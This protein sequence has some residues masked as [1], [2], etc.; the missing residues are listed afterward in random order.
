MIV[1]CQLKS[2]NYIA[3]EK[4]L[5][6]TII[7]IKIPDIKNNMEIFNEVFNEFARIEKKFSKNSEASIIWKINN[8]A[9][10][11]TEFILDSEEKN[12]FEKSKYYHEL[13]EGYFDITMFTLGQFWNF[14]KSEDTNV[15]N[16]LKKMEELKQYIG[17][18]NIILSDTMV[19]LKNQKLKID[20]GGIAKGYAIDRAV[21][22]LKNKNIQSAIINAGGDIFALGSKNFDDYWNIAIQHPLKESEYLKILKLKNSAIATSGD[23]QRFVIFENKKYCHIFNPKTSKNT[24]YYSSVTV[25]GN[26]AVESDALATAIFAAENNGENLIKHL[27]KR[28][29]NLEIYSY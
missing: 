3:Q 9:E 7:T 14:T 20:L 4:I 19:K 28:I 13:T 26:S 29:P 21:E 15:P 27:K 24:Q 1:S 16:I 17:F 2:I 25:V 5:M 6:D 8:R 10:T 23:Y 18:E 11:Q 12:I 22:I